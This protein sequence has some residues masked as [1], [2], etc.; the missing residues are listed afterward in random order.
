MNIKITNYWIEIPK[1]MIIKILRAILYLFIGAFSVA[2]VGFIL[3]IKS[4]PE[5]SIWHT[6]EL[7][8]EYSSRSKV[9][10]LKEYIELEDRL[11]DELHR[12]VYDKLPSDKRTNINRY[13]QGSLSAPDRL[14]IQ[15]N[16]TVE[17]P[18]ADPKIGVL[19]IHGMSDSPYSLN[20]QTKYLKKRGAYIINLRM[21]G[22]GT[23]PSGLVELRWQDMAKVVEMGMKHLAEQI[24]DKPIYMMG[25]STGAPL[26]LN[27]TLN[28]ISN[29]K[30]AKPKGLILYSPA[31]G[32][33]SA[34][35]F[36]IWQSRMG[37]LFGIDK[38]A[39]T[40]ILP[41]YDPYK[42]GSFSVNAGDQVYRLSIE[43]QKQFDNITKDISKLSKIPP[44]L[45]FASAVDAT[46]KVPDIINK[47]YNRLPDNNSTLVLFDVNHNYQSTQLISPKVEKSL[48]SL[49][50]F[51]GSHNYQVDIITNRVGKNRPNLTQVTI[52]KFGTFQ[53]KRLDLK[54]AKGLYSLSHL[55]IP[56]SPYDPIYGVNIDE[57]YN[58]IRLGSI[59]SHGENG[60]LVIP[61]SYL[62]RQRW[63]P[64]HSYTKDRVLDF[65]GLTKIMQ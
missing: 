37:D 38:L 10:N 3:Y 60:V 45:S 24:G 36:A 57:E 54:W 15:W 20:A 23:I 61:S 48:K 59:V 28:S 27:Y 63:N 42:Y 7:G 29:P 46:I 34:A 62:Q 43:A 17:L 6:T 35:A 52:D 64:F 58:G 18:T 55:A 56:I 1:W 53:Q 13:T 65:L 32:V 4:L 30:L 8:S 12:E 22:H 21:P 33:T 25:Y 47:L 51:K 19:M 16:R 11:F 44:I 9:T 14:P 40:N 31:I 39:W 2:I 50:S 5:L 41:E 49:L 26:A